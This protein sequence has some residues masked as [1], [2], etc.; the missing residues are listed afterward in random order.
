MARKP[1][2]DH[3]PLPSAGLLAS[4]PC[5]APPP[6]GPGADEFLA[7]IEE[8]ANQRAVGIRPQMLGG[9][10]GVALP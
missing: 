7:A 4:R 8:L 3:P 6:S 1:A 10:G 5:P 9:R 2:A